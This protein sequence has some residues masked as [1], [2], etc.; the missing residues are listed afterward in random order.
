M[1]DKIDKAAEQYAAATTNETGAFAAEA[2]FRLGY[3]DF[4]LKRYDEALAALAQSVRIQ[5]TN[6]FADEA[7]LFSGRAALEKKDFGQAVGFFQPLGLTTNS[8][9]AEAT[10]WYARSY[11]RQNNYAEA[12]R[13]LLLL[14]PRFRNEGSPILPD[15]L[16][17]CAGAMMAQG[18]YDKATDLFTE[19][20]QRGA[21]GD[22][23]SDVLRLQATCLHYTKQF[24]NSLNYTTRYLLMNNTNAAIPFMNEVLFMHGENQYLSTPLPMVKALQDFRIFLNLFPADTNANAATLR[25]SQILYRN[26]EWKEA[27]K[28]IT[29]LAQKEPQGKLFS[30]VRFIAGD[31]HFR[32]EAWN[33]AVTNLTLFVNRS[34][35]Q[36]PNYDTALMEMALADQRLGKMDVSITHL[37]SLV[38]ACPN[39]DHKPMALA[40]LGRLL[41]ESKQFGPAR[42]YLQQLCT[43][44]S[45][46]PQR[47]AGEYYMGWI[48]LNENN[49]AEAE[50][51]FT[52]VAQT[53]P[54]DP[55]CAD[56]L[57][58]L[59]LLNLKAEKYP[60]T[61]A[62]MTDLLNRFP[63][64]AKNDEALYSAGVALSRQSRWG[65][66]IANCFFPF[67]N[68]FA[69]SELID[70][71]Y[72]EWAWCERRQNR[73]AE[74]VKLYD[75]LITTCPSSKLIDR[76]R[77][78]KS[79]LTF[80]K[81][82]FDNTIRDLNNTL[83]AEKDPILREQ[84]RQR[85][86]WAY[87]GKGDLDKAAKAFE[88]LLAEFPQ[89]EVAATAHYQAGEALMKLME[90]KPANVHFA[91]TLVAKNSKDVHESAMLRLGETHALLKKW[92]EA[93]A[94]YDQFQGTYPK[95]KWIQHARFGSGW[96]RENT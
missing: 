33:D 6:G 57:L 72:Y 55:L 20:E 80:D 43:V 10:L 70:R 75:L 95:S 12:E 46:A 16:F 50:K 15:L 38:N 37:T 86:A 35:P 64:F 34:Q 82:D 61:H 85:L 91:A 22:R 73:P 65:E 62:K 41:Y 29:P 45:N 74:A 79:E 48:S 47:V 25:V 1:T 77:F 8:V 11:A 53:A 83:A 92:P 13:F 5:T 76:A 36:E 93:A 51:H 71:T 39:S 56:S 78:E 9:S 81:K 89:T 32:V 44:F 24:A 42:G 60:E 23:L 4:H 31:S 30:Q 19:I 94:V 66:A 52:Y 59:G 84:V 7:R 96:A 17:E 3:V 26:S 18:K 28:T 63:T 27:L 88:A 69:K 2:Y 90:F 87:L 54:Q 68:R 49:G 40:E 67:T 21:K 58:Q 14:M